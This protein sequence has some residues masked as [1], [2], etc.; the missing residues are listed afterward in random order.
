MESNNSNS[1]NPSFEDVFYNSELPSSQQCCEPFDSL[2]LGTQPSDAEYDEKYFNNAEPLNIEDPVER[3]ALVEG[4]RLLNFYTFCGCKTVYALSMPIECNASSAANK[5]KPWKRCFREAFEKCVQR[6]ELCTACKIAITYTFSNREGSQ[7]FSHPYYQCEEGV[8]CKLYFVFKKNAASFKFNN[9]KVRED[10][11]MLFVEKVSD[12]LVSLLDSPDRIRIAARV[13]RFFNYMVALAEGASRPED[14]CNVA[15]CRSDEDIIVE[16]ILMQPIWHEKALLP[17]SIHRVERT[18]KLNIP[19]VQQLLDDTLAKDDED[20]RGTRTLHGGAAWFESL[21]RLAHTTNCGYDSGVSLLFEDERDVN[22][23]LN[24]ASRNL[25]A[26]LRLERALTCRHAADVVK[27]INYVSMLAVNICTPDFNFVES[28]HS[29]ARHPLKKMMYAHI[30][31]IEKAVA[32]EKY[33]IERTHNFIQQVAFFKT[34]SSVFSDIREAGLPASNIIYVRIVFPATNFHHAQQVLLALA[35]SVADGVASFLSN[36]HLDDCPHS[37]SSTEAVSF[38]IMYEE[39]VWRR[40][41]ILHPREDEP[42]Y[43]DPECATPLTLLSNN[44][45]SLYKSCPFSSNASNDFGQQFARYD[46]LLKI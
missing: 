35:P 32:L 7:P 42:S 5:L 46:Q 22:R 40:S 36:E 11:S 18:L 30:F 9:E 25:D 15:G 33:V 38:S 21:F 14:E 28:C 24:I 26:C 3:A 43:E 23:M 45:G 10:F 4:G 1:D 29:F 41:E 17:F 20:E 16:E 2:N 6:A 27:Q 37:D 39:E 13:K 31:D 12:A 8:M 19:E 44:D 34:P